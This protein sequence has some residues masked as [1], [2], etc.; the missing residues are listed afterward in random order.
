MKKQLAYANDRGI[1]FVL[2]A[3]SQELSDGKILVK[4]MKLG[5]QEE[6]P[7]DQIVS[8]LLQETDR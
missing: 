1:R 2:I 8:R 6:C 3:G 5:T 7:L 4:D